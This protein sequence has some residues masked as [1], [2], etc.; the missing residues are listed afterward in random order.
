[1]RLSLMEYWTQIFLWSPHQD[2]DAVGVTI[3]EEDAALLRIL[4][5]R[6]K[7]TVMDLVMVANMM[8]MLDV[9]GI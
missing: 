9:K 5:V 4:V 2:K 3:K 8:A 7:V 1:V 6:E